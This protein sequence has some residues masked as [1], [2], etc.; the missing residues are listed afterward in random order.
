M[1]LV[2]TMH[3]PVASMRVQLERVI[4]KWRGMFV[5]SVIAYTEQTDQQMVEYL[6]E[7]GMEMVVGGMWGEARTTGVKFLVE[8]KSSEPALVMDFDKLLHI[9]DIY[10]EDFK[11]FV[12]Q[13]W[14]NNILIGR[15]QKAWG[16]FP[17]SWKETE[18]IANKIG[19]KY[20]ETTEREY[21]LATYVLN[22]Q[23]QKRIAEE[24]KFISFDTL[25]EWVNILGGKNLDY[26]ESDL[27]DWEDPDRNLV[28]IE[29]LGREQWKKEMFD[30]L[31]EWQKRIKNL[32]EI[33]G[34]LG[35]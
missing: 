11:K 35:S 20:F 14:T 17:D 18:V 15:S 29:K 24:S 4:E 2:V 8:N 13:S 34:V 12:G 16:T 25:F 3:D 9:L 27:F 10:F 26:V 21:L 1:N 22:T 30:S 32:K 7:Q 23:G 19:N 28:E 5:K 6:G 33:V 31:A